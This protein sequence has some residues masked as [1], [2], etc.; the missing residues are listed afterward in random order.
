MRSEEDD[1]KRERANRTAW[2]KGQATDTRQT[3]SQSRSDGKQSLGKKEW[4]GASYTCLFFRWQWET[5]RD[6][7][8]R[9]NGNGEW[10]GHTVGFCTFCTALL[11]GRGRRRLGTALAHIVSL[12][13][14]WESSKTP[15]EELVPKEPEATSLSWPSDGEPILCNLAVGWLVKRPQ[16]GP[17]PAGRSWEQLVLGEK[18]ATPVWRLFWAEHGLVQW[19]CGVCIVCLLHMARRG[20]R[21]CKTP[22]APQQTKVQD[23]MCGKPRPTTSWDGPTGRRMWTGLGCSPPACLVGT[24]GLE[25]FFCFQIPRDGHGLVH[26]AIGRRNVKTSGRRRG[27][28]TLTSARR[29]RFGP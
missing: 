9:M 22:R 18:D 6:G 25:E 23:W 11:G 24:T 7:E 26:G 2:G 5:R 12:K 10:D 14:T 1:A 13:W 8:P 16:S 20:E 15:A 17:A 28:P 27:H 29:P 19:T 3:L 4:P 21:V